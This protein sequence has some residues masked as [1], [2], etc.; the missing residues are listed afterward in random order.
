VLEI[1]PSFLRSIASHWPAARHIR[2]T[3]PMRR[4]FSTS[5]ALPS[6]APTPVLNLKVSVQPSKRDPG[7]FIFVRMFALAMDEVYSESIVT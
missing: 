4:L 2:L 1:V 5:H 6:A 3:A 7:L